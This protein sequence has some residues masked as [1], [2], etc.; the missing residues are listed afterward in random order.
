MGCVPPFDARLR[1]YAG[2]TK[3]A[4]IWKI[5]NAGLDHKRLYKQGINVY[6]KQLVWARFAVSCCTLG[7]LLE[8][9]RAETH[10]RCPSL[11]LIRSETRI[12]EPVTCLFLDGRS[13]QEDADKTDL[14]IASRMSLHARARIC[15]FVHRRPTASS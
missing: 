1:V 6:G 5:S 7:W 12:G 3:G 9:C 4:N 13:L 8:G 2:L 15:A 10:P 11:W 14:F